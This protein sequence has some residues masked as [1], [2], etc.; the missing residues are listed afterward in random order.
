MNLNKSPVPLHHPW[1]IVVSTQCRPSDSHREVTHRAGT[2]ADAGR[3]RPYRRRRC[4]GGPGAALALG[5]GKTARVVTGRKRELAHL[6]AAR[7]CQKAN[8]LTP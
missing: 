6:G 8:S 1:V 4:D 2:R 3:G 7:A 5:N